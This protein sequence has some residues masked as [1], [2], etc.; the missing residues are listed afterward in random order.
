MASPGPRQ[1]FHLPDSGCRYGVHRYVCMYGHGWPW[2][3]ACRYSLVARGHA[4]HVTND[5]LP[6]PLSAH[7]PLTAQI[8][9]QS[10]L[11]SSSVVL[12][13]PLTPLGPPPRLPRHAGAHILPH[14]YVMHSPA[15]PDPGWT[16]S[17][18]HGTA[19]ISPRTAA[20]SLPFPGARDS[21]MCHRR[22]HDSASR[23][24]ACC[25][26]WTCR[27]EWAVP[28]LAVIF[29]YMRTRHR[30]HTTRHLHGIRPT[31]GPL[32]SSPPRLS[33]MY[34][35][36]RHGFPPGKHFGTLPTPGIQ[37]PSTPQPDRAGH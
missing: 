30:G 26:V 21:A 37:A 10:L 17:H 7:C 24:I 20:S 35:L 9:G 4:F 19:E 14:T 18:V 16:A 13:P 8:C 11:L 32:G 2:C 1:P 25:A 3:A 29:H 22:A 6:L 31:S 23:Q 28:S 12:H 33:A 36:W 15:E 5:K 34:V 27:R